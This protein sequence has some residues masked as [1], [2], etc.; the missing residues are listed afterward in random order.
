M[1]DFC[2]NNNILIPNI[3][4]GTWPIKDST[5]LEESILIFLVLLL[6]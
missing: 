3:G 4:F 5:I 6:L 1:N 2:L